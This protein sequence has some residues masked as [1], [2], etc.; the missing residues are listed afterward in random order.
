MPEHIAEQHQPLARFGSTAGRPAPAA[1]TPEPTATGGRSDRGRAVLAGPSPE[2]A[3]IAA[4]GWSACGRCRTTS[5][6]G[7]PP[8][9]GTSTAGSLRATDG[10]HVHAENGDPPR[11]SP[12]RADAAS[13]WDRTRVFAGLV[14]TDVCTERITPTV[15]LTFAIS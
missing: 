10:R 1:T 3:A 13:G 15:G 5:H 9:R 2:P 12:S 8:P 14:P 11:T 7:R 4:A 6:G